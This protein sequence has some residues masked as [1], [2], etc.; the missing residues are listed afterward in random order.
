[1]CGEICPRMESLFLHLGM[2]EQ[3]YVKWWIAQLFLLLLEEND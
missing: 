1:M 3:V 2:G